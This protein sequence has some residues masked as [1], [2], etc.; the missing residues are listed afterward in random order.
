ML[1]MVGAMLLAA[2][3][4][5]APAGTTVFAHVSVVTME[6]ATALQDRIVE[7]AGDAIV[8]VASAQ[9]YKAPKGARI[10]DGRGLFLMPG[11]ADMHTHVAEYDDRP[12]FLAQYLAYGVTTIRSLSGNPDLL[13]LRDSIGRGGKLAPRLWISGPIVTGPAGKTGER[14]PPQVVVDSAEAARSAVDRQVEAGYDLVKLYDGLSREAFL[15]AAGEAKARGIYV[16]GHLPDQ[17]PL[18]E[19]LASGLDE[20]AHADELVS[21]HWVGYDPAKQYGALDIAGLDLDVGA[22]RQTVDGVR[23]NG[24]AVVSDLVTDQVVYE[25]IADAPGLLRERQYREVPKATV[26][27]WRARGRF[28]KWRGQAPYRR[29]RI[30]P[31]LEQLVVRLQR[32]G[33]N[34]TVGSDLGVEGMVPGYH[35]VRDIQLLEHAGLTPFEALSAGTRNAAAVAARMGK[36]SNWGRVAVGYRADLLLLAGNPLSTTRNLWRVK[37]VML[38]GKWL[39]P[40]RLV[41]L[42]RAGTSRNGSGP[43]SPGR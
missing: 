23:R 15:A 36:P 7:V 3:L 5:A 20:I 32:A 8:A 18:A 4:A 14:G 12:D 37:G 10:I 17:I 21:Y 34:L 25:G 35:L 30:Q 31:F 22:T 9:G 29:D 1:L 6:D 16:V 43:A 39:P 40:E 24:L 13:R 26:D 19:A 11:L 42:R 2:P 28:V 38:A 41:E 27:R 33:V